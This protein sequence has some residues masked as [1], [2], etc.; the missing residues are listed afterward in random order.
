[1]ILEDVRHGPPRFRL[2]LLAPLRYLAI[3]HP[4]KVRYDIAL[5]VATGLAAWVTYVFVAP[6]MPIF[7]DYGLIKYARDLLIMAVPFM[8][9]A[10]AAVAMGMPGQHLDRR[11]PGADLIL[12]GRALTMRQFVC[13]LLG[14]LC[15]LGLV[16]L[17]ASIAAPLLRDTVLQILGPRAVLRSIVHGIGTCLLLVSLSTLTV[18]IFW[19]LYFLTDLVNRPA[20]PDD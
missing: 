12:D 5:P 17:L 2:R 7:G 19:S 9:G 20:R 4:E 18:T 11:P 3:S 1:M 8:V 10:L 15:F 6:K 14:Y 16:I 13:Y